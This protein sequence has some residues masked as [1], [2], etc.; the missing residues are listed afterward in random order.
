MLL[1]CGPPFSFFAAWAGKRWWRPRGPRC[2]PPLCGFDSDKLHLSLSGLHYWPRS[3]PCPGVCLTGASVLSKAPP[4]GG[5][6]TSVD[7]W[8]LCASPD[9]AF[10]PREPSRGC[11]CG[12]FYCKTLTRLG[13]SE[14]ASLP[15]TVL[16]K[17]CWS[18][19]SPEN[20]CRKQSFCHCSSAAYD[21]AALRGSRP[22]PTVCRLT[23]RHAQWSPGCPIAPSDGPPHQKDREPGLWA[24]SQRAL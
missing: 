14:K 16:K 9:A 24:T 23:S 15:Q 10:S 21:E 11:G 4:R 1:C 12:C 22:S 7:S 17:C 13:I 6:P 2:G 20:S 8:S 18:S 5:W 3:Q 19:W